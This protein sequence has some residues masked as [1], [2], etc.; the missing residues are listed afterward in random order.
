LR[1]GLSMEAKVD[2]ADQGGEP[3]TAA[4][5]VRS[6]TTQ[7]FDAQPSVADRIVHDIIAANLGGAGTHV[8]A[9]KRSQRLLLGSLR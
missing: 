5:S 1:V 4:T 9:A 3:L 6:S 2:I 7:A 8:S